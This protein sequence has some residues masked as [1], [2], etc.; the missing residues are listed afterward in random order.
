MTNNTPAPIIILL[1]E[2]ATGYLRRGLKPWGIPKKSKLPR[3]AQQPIPQFNRKE[4]HDRV[5]R[6]LHNTKHQREETLKAAFQ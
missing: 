5:T 6:L 1:P 2:L 3:R 4:L